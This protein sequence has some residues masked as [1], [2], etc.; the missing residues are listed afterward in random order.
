MRTMAKQ[1]SDAPL[2]LVLIP[3]ARQACTMGADFWFPSLQLAAVTVN[4][5]LLTL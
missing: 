2:L 1:F 4:T 3:K 5:L